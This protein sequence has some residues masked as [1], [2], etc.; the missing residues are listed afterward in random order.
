MIIPVLREQQ[1]INGL[2]EHLQ[3]Q[4]SGGKGQDQHELEI[5]VVDGDAEGSTIA[6]ITDQQVIA[7]TTIK[8]R[9]AQL[10]A[11]ASRATGDI[12]LL[13]HADTRLPDDGLGM[14]ADAVAGGAVWGAF[15]LGID[16]PGLAY[17]II[18]RSVDLRCRLFTLPY[19]DQ[20]IFVTSS[21]L[22]E[23]GG[24]PA[25]PLMEDVA[26]AQRLARAGHRFSLL[27][28]RV[29]SS[30]RRWQQDGIAR[31]TL[32]NWLLLLR[33]LCGADPSALAKE[34]R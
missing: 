23:I 12:I 24:M 4:G 21:G 26:L 5:I 11:G 15:R 13:L 31:R 32:R 33:Y 7:F 18:E 10:A 20:A 17:R 29:R 14:I 28:T 1:R 22:T 30:P 16:A 2:I 25:F 34:Y 3:G 19:G 27:N 6:A 9:G 8:G